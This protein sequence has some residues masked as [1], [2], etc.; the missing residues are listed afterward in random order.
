MR[1]VT[2]TKF[3]KPWAEYDFFDRQ[4]ADAVLELVSNGMFIKDAAEV[5]GVSAR[6]VHSWT[7]SDSNGFR[8]QLAAARKSSAAVHAE[9]IVRIADGQA[10]V[11]SCP[12]IEAADSEAMQRW[13][14]DFNTTDR[15][16]LRIQARQW[17]VG[18]LSPKEFG[19]RVEVT[20]QGGDT[21]IGHAHA[22][23]N[24]PDDEALRLFSENARRIEHKR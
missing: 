15:D 12:S 4:K 1:E 8:A 20:H 19:D 2:P 22:H 7:I 11:M 13:I 14:R 17:Y 10:P 18:K 3:L 21:P 24:M 6:S 23:A 16:R 9:D 5:V